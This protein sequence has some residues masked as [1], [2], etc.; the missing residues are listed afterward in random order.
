MHR[1]DA[2]GPRALVGVVEVGVGEHQ[3][4]D[5]V[6]R[7]GAEPLPVHA[8]H[9]QAAPIYFFDLQRVEDGEDV[10]AEQLEAIG[11]LAGAGLAVAAAIGADEAEVLGEFASLVVPHMQVGTERIPEHQR[12]RAFAALDLD[13][14]RAAVDVDCRHSNSP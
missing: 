2:V 11:A 9:R 12:R 6:R 13:I 3:L 4:F 14:E 10:A 8:A 1:L 7:V 5:A